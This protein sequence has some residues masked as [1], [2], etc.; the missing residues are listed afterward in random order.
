MARFLFLGIID[1]CSGMALGEPLPERHDDRV[2]FERIQC[3][4]LCAAI[5]TSERRSY[6]E[7][8]RAKKEG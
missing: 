2:A 7:R 8:S 1:D 4:A 5:P 3:I 6:A